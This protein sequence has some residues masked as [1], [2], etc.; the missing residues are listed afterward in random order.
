MRENQFEK[1]KRLDDQGREYWSSR[2]LAKE[3]EYPDYRKFLAVIEKA[4]TACENSGE[5]IHNH[6]VHK[7][8]MV[9]IGSGAE[10]PIETMYLSRYACYLVVPE[11][12]TD[13]SIVNILPA[14]VVDLRDDGLGQTMVGLALGESRILCRVTR[15]SAEVLGL[16][17]GKVLFAQIKGV[18]IVE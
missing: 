3:L 5:V 11:K 1:I 13:S 16:H 14:R 4:K 17:P 8:E 6:F 9:L 10:R 2:E 15:K 18:A 7:D 12:R